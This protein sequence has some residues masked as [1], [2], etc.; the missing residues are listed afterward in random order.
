[1]ALM[2][3]SD[4]T[5]GDS[6]MY[7]SDFGTRNRGAARIFFQNREWKSQKCFN[8]NRKVMSNLFMSFVWIVLAVDIYRRFITGISSWSSRNF[9]LNLAKCFN[10]KLSIPFLLG[11]ASKIRKFS[12]PKFRQAARFLGPKNAPHRDS[13]SQN[14]LCTRYFNQEFMNRGV[15]PTK[16]CFS[17]FSDFHW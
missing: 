11:G 8:K 4:S 5:Y 15:N 1:M 16:L 13:A 17:S 6:S 2:L 9:Q 10:F 12:I 3:L 14:R 7:T